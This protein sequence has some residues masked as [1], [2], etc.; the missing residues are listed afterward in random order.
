MST[1]LDLVDTQ[2][3]ILTSKVDRI[4]GTVE[5]LDF[6][7]AL[8][9]IQVSLAIMQAADVAGD[10]EWTIAPSMAMRTVEDVTSFLR[11]KRM[12]SVRLLAIPIMAIKES[13]PM[14]FTVAP[15]L[16]DSDPP[17]AQQQILY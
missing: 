9:E 8:Y 6:A 4:F 15:S 16:S 3:A 10:G 2:A 1:F 13:V 5:G 14:N 12:D 17:G 7:L 11:N